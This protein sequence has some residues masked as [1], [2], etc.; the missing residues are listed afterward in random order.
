MADNLTEL[1]REHI[2]RTFTTAI[3]R[4][5]SPV[6]IELIR[7][8]QIIPGGTVFKGITEKADY[9]SLHQFH[10]PDTPL[11]GGS[12]EIHAKPQ[13]NVAFGQI[14][15]EMGVDTRIMN[16]PKGD[17]QLQ[18][19]AVRDGDN[20]IYSV[21]KILAQLVYSSME[22]SEEDATHTRMQ[23][24][25]SALIENRTYAGITRSG[26]TN[27]YWQSADY[28]NWD[29]A[30]TISKA[31]ISD[32][33]DAVL[34]FADNPQDIMIVLG[35]TLFNSLKREFEASGIYDNDGVDMAKQGF[36]SMMYEG[37]KIVKDFWLERQTATTFTHG[38]NA[39]TPGAN[40]GMDGSG[41]YTGAQAAFVLDMS[42]W[43][44]RYWPTNEDTS[45]AQTQT[46]EWAG[47]IEVTQPFDQSKIIGGV[48]KTLRRFKYKMN[49]TCDLPNRNLYRANVSG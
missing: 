23:G 6:L 10:G 15:H 16:L 49:L 26:A 35:T 22:D 24:L 29:T 7:R 14:P 31:N 41:S 9:A 27:E 1:T 38:P 20:I 25:I 8:K 40:A 18:D 48:E 33:L 36:S 42:T 21:G 17:H 3:R 2:N 13:W 34:E 11:D 39:G 5:K 12:K 47:Y 19:V 43:N 30:V 46:D 44:L 45:D 28:A 37:Y 4:T 32:W